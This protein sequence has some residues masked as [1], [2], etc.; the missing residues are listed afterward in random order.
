[1]RKAISTVVVAVAFVAG[2]SGVATAARMHVSTTRC[3]SKYTPACTKPKIEHPPVSPR[4]VSAGVRYALP[5]VTITSNA[6]IR[7]IQVT[8]APKPVRTI[9][10]TGKG[11]TQFALKGLGVSTVGLSSGGHVIVFKVTDVKGKTA[12]K[13]LRYSVCVSTPVFTG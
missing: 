2:A 5:T 9:T 13:T 1:L 6:G 7:R 4:C 8:A 11:P 10:F 3:G 12:S